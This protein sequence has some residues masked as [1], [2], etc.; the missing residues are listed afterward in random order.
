MLRWELSLG[1]YILTCNYIISFVRCSI[2]YLKIGLDLL[3][4]NVSDQVAL[5]K[6]ERGARLSTLD[7]RVYLSGQTPS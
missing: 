3:D 5:R 6:R 7:N 4:L 1:N 2:I